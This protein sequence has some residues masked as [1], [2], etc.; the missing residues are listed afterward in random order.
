MEPISCWSSLSSPYLTQKLRTIS[1]SEQ[2]AMDLLTKDYPDIVNGLK[3]ADSPPVYGK[4][5]DMFS[6]TDIQNLCL[7]NHSFSRYGG[8]VV[9]YGIDNGSVGESMRVRTCAHDC[10]GQVDVVC[11]IF[12]IRRSLINPF[13]LSESTRG[14]NE[15]LRYLNTRTHTAS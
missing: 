6:L 8:A 12:V 15:V 11:S 13:H 3:G 10:L 9:D 1:T 2:R 5:R 4:N 14:S 7:D